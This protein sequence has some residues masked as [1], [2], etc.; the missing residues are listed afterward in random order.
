MNAILNLN[1]DSSDNSSIITYR[2][3]PSFFQDNDAN[4]GF[5]AFFY[6]SQAAVI[7]AACDGTYTKPNFRDTIIKGSVRTTPPITS[8]LYNKILQQVFLGATDN[9]DFDPQTGERG[10]DSTTFG[11][12]NVQRA[13]SST[14]RLQ[15]GGVVTPVVETASGSG[16]NPWKP[17]TTPSGQQLC[18]IFGTGSCAI[19]P[20]VNPPSTKF[21]YIGLGLRLMGWILMGLTLFAC[22]Y[23]TIW[24]AQNRKEKIG[25]RE[26][27]RRDPLWLAP[28]SRSPNCFRFS[29]T[30]SI[31]TPLPPLPRIC[32][33]LLH[34][35]LPA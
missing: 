24:I 35:F 22:L 31:S 10:G 6:D 34:L 7:L 27:G 21:E 30:I 33:L 20:Q 14:R 13:P 18:F 19:P 32:I 1:N 29:L 8:K 26:G 25:E 4:Q 12:Y 3:Q 28:V 23:T 11:L 5:N 15:G 9:V 2:F 16:S 17:V